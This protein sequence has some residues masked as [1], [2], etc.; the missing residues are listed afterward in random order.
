M[1]NEDPA[2]IKNNLVRT[3]NSGASSYHASGFTIST[4][5]AAVHFVSDTV[6]FEVYNHLGCR[7]DGNALGKLP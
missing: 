4:A 7:M 1:I 2:M 5:D 3:T 6:D